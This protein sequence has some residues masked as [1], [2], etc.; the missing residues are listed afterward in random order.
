M[1][2]PQP[3]D[4]APDIRILR[5]E[6]V[7]ALTDQ[8][9]KVVRDFHGRP[10]Q[11]TDVLR[12]PTAVSGGWR[13]PDDDNPNRRNALKVHGYRAYEPLRAM[14]NRPGSLIERRHVLAGRRYLA[15]YECGVLG[16]RSGRDDSGVRGSGGVLYPAEDQAARIRAVILAHRAVGERGTELL[17]FI[18]L[19]IPD[20]TRASLQHYATQ[21]GFSPQLAMGLLVAALD[22][23]AAHY[24]IGAQA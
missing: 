7:R 4:A 11:F 18:I 20:P 13:D 8:S 24:G 6:E 21:R 1:P 23:L 14:G 17:R 10:M 3:S 2:S 19:G 12:E 5:I 9:G 15:D 16:A 22:H